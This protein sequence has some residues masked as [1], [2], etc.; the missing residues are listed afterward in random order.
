[1]LHSLARRHM[2]RTIGILCV[3][4]LNEVKDLS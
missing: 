3:V 2:L 1:L 4:I